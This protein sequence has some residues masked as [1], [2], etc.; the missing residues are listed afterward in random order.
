MRWNTPLSEPHADLL[1]KQLAAGPGMSVLDLGCGWGDLLARV[2]VGSGAASCAGIGLDT[3]PVHLDRGRRL[4]RERG[5][6]EQVRLV[7]SPAQE[8]SE[9]A[10]RIICIGASHAW[11]STRQ[12]LAALAR[13]V[14]PGGRLLFGDGC[15]EGKLTPA[16]AAMFDDVLPLAEIIDVVRAGNWRT[17]H[18]ST[19]SQRESDEFE[20]RWRLGSE[21]WLR[22]NPAA[23]SAPQVRDELDE[24]LAEYVGTYRGVLGFCYL[25]LGR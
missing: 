12:A 13:L 4:L 11:G 9:P 2:V 22:A 25:V 24:R 8:W 20:S 1:I 23:A 5:L 14:R 18:L 19:A 7:E 21:E 17:L 10:D 3:D 6:H 15:W 16:A